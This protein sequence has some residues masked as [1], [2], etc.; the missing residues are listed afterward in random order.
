MTCG[1]FYFTYIDL[2]VLCNLI[3]YNNSLITLKDEQIKGHMTTLAEILQNPEFGPFH[4]TGKEVN[5]KF[6]TARFD[7][8]NPCSALKTIKY[9]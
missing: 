1:T 7:K 6:L 5:G 4:V 9:K 2:I 3:K 8:G